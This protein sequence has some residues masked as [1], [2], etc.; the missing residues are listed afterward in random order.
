MVN[1][2]HS[3]IPPVKYTEHR[4]HTKLMTPFST[5]G[6]EMKPRVVRI[7]VTD[8]DA[9]D[10]SSDEDCEVYKRPRVKK[11]LSEIMI[12]S[13][14]SSSE[15]DVVSKSRISKCKKKKKSGKVGA[16]A[17]L[18]PAAKQPAGKKFR[19]VRQRP[20]GKW[21]AEIRD[22]L[23]RVR[24]WLGTY[25]TAEEAA[26][27]Y[28]NAAIQLRGPDALTNFA[29]PPPKFPSQIKQSLSSGYNSGEE[30]HNNINN[31]SSPVS[32]LR[33]PSPSNEEAESRTSKE[34]PDIAS[35]MR[36]MRDESS[37]SETLSAFS[38]YSTFDNT[39]FPNDIFDF[40]SSVPD[41]F[42]CTE[43]IFKDDWDGLFYDSSMD[44]GF[45]LS[46][47]RADDHFQDIGDIFASDNLVAI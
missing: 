29:T 21:A 9:T 5:N 24:L 44:F 31:L 12:A 11:F 35:D 26:M 34:S 18:K 10:S 17:T 38:E 28:D 47:W 19:G 37:V 1:S 43:G 25:D 33:C 6:Q 2:R 40:K 41:L 30:S 45:G 14:S 13:S 27:V 8:G 16:P 15:I 42:G 32:V 4:K 36:E 20:W 23:R 3:V 46:T 22:P 7:S 39:L